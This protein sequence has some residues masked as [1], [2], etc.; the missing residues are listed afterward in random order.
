MAYKIETVPAAGVAAPP[1]PRAP[2]VTSDKKLPGT[3]T[4]LPSSP[5]ASSPDRK[6]A[7]VVSC[8]PNSVSGTKPGSSEPSHAEKKRMVR[9]SMD[10]HLS[11]HLCRPTLRTQVISS[12]GVI[13]TE[14][15]GGGVGGSQWRRQPEHQAGPFILTHTWQED[16]DYAHSCMERPHEPECPRVQAAE[17]VRGV[18]VRIQGPFSRA[19]GRPH[20]TCMTTV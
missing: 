13:V 9:A 1:M 20:D 3:P 16:R 11:S 19:D 14:A 4:R 15:F 8:S 10:H 7:A 5:S 2:F 17:Q 18:P 12:V 6:Q